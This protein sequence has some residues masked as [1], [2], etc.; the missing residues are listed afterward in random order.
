[1]LAYETNL[2]GRELCARIPVTDFLRANSDRV[3]LILAVGRP[4][5]VPNAVIRRGVA[6]VIDDR[7]VF[8]IRQKSFR[9]NDVKT[10]ALA[11]TV[12]VQ[13]NL[14]VTVLD[15]NRLPNYLS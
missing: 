12:L 3:I 9:N 1:M 7:F 4:V 8:G 13:R 5:Q 6:F 10:N 11:L 2:V 14:N 15:D